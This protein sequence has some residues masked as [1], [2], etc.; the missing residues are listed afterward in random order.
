MIRAS[1][2]RRRDDLAVMLI[3]V[4]LATLLLSGAAP[5]TAPSTSPSASDRSP[6]AKFEKEIAA[7]EAAD[8]L[9]PPP[10]NAVLFVGSST[11]RM[12]KTLAEDFADHKVINRG[13]GGSEL[14][15][16]VYFADRIVIPYHPRMVVVFAGTNDINAGKT[17]EQVFADYQAFVAKVRA[18]LPDV[19]IAYLSIAPCP[20]RWSQADMQMKANHLIRDFSAAGAS[21]DYIEVW[22]QLLGSD[23]KP[24]ADLYLADGL[25][26]N[27]E[28]YKIRAAAIRPY[29]NGSGGR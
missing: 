8:K 15:D 24:R 21:L 9:S 26:P 17:P 18:A 16:S 19:R 20:S 23:G 22:D 5:S 3:G 2:M 28:G 27:A 11:I 29:L 10:K 14:A 13:F 4:L 6:S 12:W 25:H 7:F 1:T